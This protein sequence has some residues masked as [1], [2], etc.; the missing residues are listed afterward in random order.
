MKRL[1]IGAAIFVGILGSSVSCKPKDKDNQTEFD[2]GP[3][4]ENLANNYIIPGYDALYIDLNSLDAAWS[5][6]IGDQTQQNLTAVQDAWLNANLSF[7]RV[8]AFDFGPAMTVGLL[9]AYGTFPADTIQ[10]ANNITT[11]SYSLTTAENIDAIGFDALDFLLFRQGALDAFQNSLATCT[12]VSDLIAKMKSEINSVKNGWTTYKTTFISGTSNA[13][14]S[15][16]ALLINT[17]CRDFELSKT[18][19]IGIPIGMQSLGIQQPV[20]L[21]ARRSGKGLELLVAS[22]EASRRIFSGFNYSGTSNGTGFDD[23]LTAIE[24]ST[25]STTIQSRLDFAIATPPT[26]AE[27]IEQRMQSNNQTLIDYYNYLQGTVVFMKTDM[28]SAF[29]VLITYQDNDGD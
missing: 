5:N 22:M 2:K 23:Y 8:K 3:I 16:F 6:F 20:Y 7:Q 15:P 9:S 25:L 21:E 1:A 19:K 27:T 26:W 17:F 18:A 29:G 24:R 4:L 13:S 28:A 14:T 11:G 12:Y 10:I